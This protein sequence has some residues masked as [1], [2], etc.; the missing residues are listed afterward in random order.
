MGYKDQ[1]DALLEAMWNDQVKALCK[2]EKHNWIHTDANK[3]ELDVGIGT[4][5]RV[6]SCDGYEHFQVDLSDL[7]MHVFEAYINDADDGEPEI[8]A[9]AQEIYDRLKQLTDK[10]EAML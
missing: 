5:E 6:D 2:C 7:I 9:A 8:K 10:M 1:T 3:I 4:Y